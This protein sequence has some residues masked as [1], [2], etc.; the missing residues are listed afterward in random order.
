[1]KARPPRP[2]VPIVKITTYPDE[3]DKESWI[4]DFKSHVKELKLEE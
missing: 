4:K 1:M 3:F 2:N